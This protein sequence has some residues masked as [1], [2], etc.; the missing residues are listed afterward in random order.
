MVTF[1]AQI[2]HRVTPYGNPCNMSDVFKLSFSCSGPSGCAT[3]TLGVGTRP[4]LRDELLP[5]SGPDA[6]RLAGRSSQQPG[7]LS[8]V[9]MVGYLQQQNCK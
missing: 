1:E 4:D 3:S 8:S 9:Y 5:T 6:Q 2:L 7:D